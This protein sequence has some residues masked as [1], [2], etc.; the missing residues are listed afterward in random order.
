[1]RI[2]LSALVFI[3]F[4]A[5]PANSEGLIGG[6]IGGD[7]GRALDR[8]HEQLGNPLDVPGRVI[9]ETTVETVGPALAQAIRHSRDD[10]R[11]S[12][13]SPIPHHI[14]RLMRNCFSTSLLRSVRYR[15]GQGHELSVQANSFRFGDAS[16]VALIDTI[17]FANARDADRNIWLWAHEIKHIDQYERWGLTNFAKRYVRDHQSVEREADHAANRCVQ[18]SRPSSKNRQSGPRSSV[19]SAGPSNSPQVARFCATRFGACQM[20]VAV[21]IGSSCYCPSAGGPIWGQ[22]H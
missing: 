11:R 12:G 15:V 19:S 18:S 6:L 10:A 9:R 20:G 21:P 4:A 2:S 8:T 22:A 16:A 3:T 1:M 13:T 14:Y 7:V 5:S 17:V